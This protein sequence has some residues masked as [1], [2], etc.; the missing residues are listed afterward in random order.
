MMKNDRILSTAGIC[1]SNA[2]KL[3]T[4]C[5]L[6]RGSLTDNW[7]F[8]DE[9]VD[10]HV[11]FVRDDYTETLANSKGS[12]AQVFVVINKTAKVKIDGEKFKY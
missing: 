8:A 1:S 7:L 9:F 10:C 5:N 6:I 12:D 11:C 2:T 3:R 4:Y